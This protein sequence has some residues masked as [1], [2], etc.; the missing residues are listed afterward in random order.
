MSIASFKPLVLS[1][2]KFK[3]PRC[4]KGDMFLKGKLTHPGKF[5]SM[6]EACSHCELSFE[7]EPGYYF[8]AMFISYA[9]NTAIFVSVWIILSL[10]Y[11]D[12]SPVEM[13]LLLLLISVICLPLIYR[14]SRTIWLSIFVKFDEG[15][16]P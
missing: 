12:Y 1:I 13:I 15:N 5:S 7:P 16:Q 3:C 14:I 6:H 11:P 2:L 9:I 8:G 10:V 4:R